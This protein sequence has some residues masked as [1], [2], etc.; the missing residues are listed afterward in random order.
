MPMTRDDNV[1]HLKDGLSELQHL[2]LGAAPDSRDRTMISGTINCIE[3]FFRY[4]LVRVPTNPSGH[5]LVRPG[6]T[7][8]EK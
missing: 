2:L 7:E 3:S 8:P 5:A 4:Y 1:K 6:K